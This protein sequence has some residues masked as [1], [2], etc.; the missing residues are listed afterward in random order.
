MQVRDPYLDGHDGE[1]MMDESLFQRAFRIYWDA[2]YQLHI[3]VN[4]DRGL[5]RVL[6]TLEANL[7]RIGSERELGQIEVELSRTFL[8]YARD[9][10]TGILT[11][12]EVEV[13]Q[14]NAKV[15]WVQ[16]LERGDRVIVSDPTIA[17]AGREVTVNPDSALAGRGD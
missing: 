13:L 5:D 3:H 16:G 10:Q 1:W 14:S 15:M 12:R 6:D 17:V 2:G 7:R 9:L 11:P 8:K 4:G